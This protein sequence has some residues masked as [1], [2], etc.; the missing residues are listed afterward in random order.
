[1]SLK[2]SNEIFINKADKI[3]KNRY[4]YSLVNYINT[5]TP[6]KIICPTHGI[7]N[8]YITIKSVL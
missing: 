5:L 2:L 4:D 7:I 6:V 3:H 1:M 8:L